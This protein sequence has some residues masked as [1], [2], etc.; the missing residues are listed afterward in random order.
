MEDLARNEIDNIIGGAVGTLRI[1]AANSRSS[2]F[3]S[4]SL[5][6]FCQL[7]P[8]VTY[9]IY[10]G[11]IAEQAQQLLNGITELGILSVPITHEDSFEVLFQRREE[12]S[13]V[14]H[15]EAVWL[16]N[17]T[18]DITLKEL[19]EMPLS[20]SAGCC[21][22]L[23]KC[24]AENALSPQILSVSTTRNTALQWA[25]EK[26]AVAVVP[27][28]PGEFLGSDLVTKRISDTTI[29]LFKTVVKVKDRPLSVIAQKFLKFYSQKRN[30]QQVCDL[31]KLLSSGNL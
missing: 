15:K 10:E 26:T 3:I 2:L 7:Y 13:A 23:K 20:V 21:D 17:T 27:I 24:C 29:D 4:T 30:S 28:E 11:G 14:F 12:L 19:S 5:K 6:D 18:S 31:K 22:L 16:D 1:S 8:K 25:Y 9:E